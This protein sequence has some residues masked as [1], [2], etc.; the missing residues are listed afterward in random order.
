MELYRYDRYTIANQIE[1]VKVK[2]YRLVCY[3]FAIASITVST[4]SIITIL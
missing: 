3:L 2:V 1:E 4:Y